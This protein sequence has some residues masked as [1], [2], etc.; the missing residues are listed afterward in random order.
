M[1]LD[2]SPIPQEHIFIDEAGF[3]LAKTR[4]RGRNII[5]QCTITDVPGQRGGNVTICP[6]MSHN[7]VLHC[8]ATLGP[9]NTAHLLNFLNTLHDN[10]FQPEQ[11][12]PGDPEQ[13]MY[14][15]IWDNMSFYWAAQV[16]N[17]FHDHPRFTI[18]YLPPYSPF[19]NPIEELFSAWALEAV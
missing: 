7:G 10:L 3:N 8:H 18:L 15:L 14:V 9:Y 12:G 5:G 19:L 16:H 13:Q 17:C 6:A 4:R 2:A 1:E 11:R